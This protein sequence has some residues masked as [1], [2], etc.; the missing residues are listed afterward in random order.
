MILATN[1]ILYTNFIGFNNGLNSHQ[2]NNLGILSQQP[3]HGLGSSI[4]CWGH[5]YSPTI[6][7][8][9]LEWDIPTLRKA[10]DT[11]FNVEI[12]HYAEAVNKWIDLFYNLQTEARLVTKSTR[13]QTDCNKEG[14]ALLFNTLNKTKKELIAKM[15]QVAVKK[16]GR[17]IATASESGEFKVKGKQNLYIPHIERFKIVLDPPKK[18]VPITIP[19]QPTENI[20]ASVT[21]NVL[22]K[23]KST[24][25][26]A[27]ENIS[28]ESTNN[29]TVAPEAKNTSISPM[30]VIMLAVI[31][32]VALKK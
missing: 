3:N 23:L 19:Q 20:I 22:Q 29:N 21:E 17:L 26:P 25:I 15:Q 6:V 18:A 13:P 16:G 12:G 14:L 1:K 7:K 28:Q 27:T 8:Q 5:A 30:S 11:V 2:L 10:A 31:A 9:S 4:T 32:Y 24:N